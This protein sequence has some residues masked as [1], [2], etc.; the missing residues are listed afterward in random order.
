MEATEAQKAVVKKL[1]Q[2]VLDIR[3]KYQKGETTLAGELGF[4]AGYTSATLA[5]LYNI[6]SMP[7]DLLRAH[8]NLDKA[9]EKC[10]CT[11]VFKTDIERVEYLF[12]LYEKL[13]KR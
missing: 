4:G 12:D 2:E 10:Y 9:I 5:D 7:V 6:V 13:V 1:A 3:A 11:A 8:Q